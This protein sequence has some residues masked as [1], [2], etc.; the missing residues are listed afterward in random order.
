MDGWMDRGVGVSQNTLSLVHSRER[1]TKQSEAL[2]Q[3]CLDHGKKGGRSLFLEV[4]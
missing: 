4:V 1:T 3:S 2:T